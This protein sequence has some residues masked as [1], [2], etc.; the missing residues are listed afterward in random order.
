[1]KV[2]VY[3]IKGETVGD[4]DLDDKIFSRP[5]NPDLVYQALQAQTANRRQPLAHAKSRGEVAGGG[6]KPWKQKGTGRARHGSIRSPLWKGGGVTHGPLKDKIYAKNI[7]K[8]MKQAA[9]WSALSKKL[10][11]GALKVVDSFGLAQPKT[12]LLDKA[13]K[14]FLKQPKKGK[15]ISALIVTGEKPVFRASANIPSVKSLR[16]S[17]LNVEDVLK[18]KNII[19]EKAALAR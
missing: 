9:L 2:A 15:K 14:S 8:K 19:V 3:N 5:W 13:L 17:G 6:R 16:F 10:A 12:N 1:M 4:I 11:S 18:H 7:N